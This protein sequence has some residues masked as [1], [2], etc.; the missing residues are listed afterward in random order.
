MRYRGIQAQDR[1][2]PIRLMCRTL[3]VSAAG[4]DAWRSRPERTR[5]ASTRTLLSASRVIHRASRETYGSPSIWDALIKQGHHID[6]HRVARLMRIDGIRAKTV[7]PWRATTSRITGGPWPRIPS[8]ASSRRRIQT[9]CGPGTAPT[10]GPQGLALPRRDPRSLLAPRD[11]L[12]D[13]VSADR[14]AGRA[15]PHHGAGEPERTSRA[16]APLGSRQPVCRDEVP[17]VAAHSRHHH[18]Y[19]PQR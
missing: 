2:D 11:R 17:A 9:G 3:A 12:G 13:G 19:E 7:T 4:S 6:A 18:Q 15:G 16:P 10:C 8:I 1:R 5:S 14:G